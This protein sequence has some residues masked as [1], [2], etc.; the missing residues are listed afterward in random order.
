[1]RC[2]KCTSKSMGN[3]T[4]T[5]HASSPTGR[6]QPVTEESE[7]KYARVALV[8]GHGGGKSAA[9]TAAPRCLTAAAGEAYTSSDVR[10]GCGTGR[11]GGCDVAGTGRGGYRQRW[12]ATTGQFLYVHC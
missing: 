11:P 1:M 4:R 2:T 5:G 6:S 3:S 7:P 10:Q 9:P 8:S 12:R